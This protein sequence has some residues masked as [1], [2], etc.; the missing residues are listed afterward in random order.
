MMEFSR[1][2]QFGMTFK[3]LMENHGTDL[4][5]S[6]LAD[7]RARTSVQQV[8][9]QELTAHAPECGSTWQELSVRYDPSTYSWK[10]VH[11]LW[12][13]VLPWSSVILPRWGMTLNG[14]VLAHQTAE[15][16]ISETVSGL[17]PTPVKSDALVTFGHA[18]MERKEKGESRPSGAKIGSQLTWDRRSLPYV[19]DGRINPV[20]HQWLMEWP[21]GWTS[22]QP[23][24]M[25][26]FREWQQ[27]HSL[28]FQVDREAA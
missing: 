17:W 8:V 27:Q 22:L 6:Y 23:L 3:P 16:P 5:M 4:L 10:T 11:C 12:E 7:F 26:R 25:G 18:T 21:L 9:V 15:R 19:T 20:L 13:E 2:S 1:L 14:H 24:E 28:F